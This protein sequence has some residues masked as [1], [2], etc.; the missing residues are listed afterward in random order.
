MGKV[1]DKRIGVLMGGMSSEREVSLKP[2]YVQV[3]PAGT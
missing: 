3:F 1:T 2:R